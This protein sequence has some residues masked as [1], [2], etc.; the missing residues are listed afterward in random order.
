MATAVYSCLMP[1]NRPP[2]MNNLLIHNA[3]IYTENQVIPQGWLLCRAG[4]IAAVGAG[5]APA[6]DVPLLDARGQ[7]LLPGF[8]DV[9]VHGALGADT[10]D[11]QVEALRTM[12][13]FYAQQ[14]VTG[15]LPTTLTAPHADILAALEAVRQFLAE[16]SP[17][18]AVLGV[19]LEGP[20]LNVDK[21]G[22]QNP[23]YVRP[24]DPQE[25]QHYLDSGL[26]RVV[27]L[28][29]EVADNRELIAACA[30]RGIT[31]SIAHT[32]ATY[33]EARDA[34]AAGIRHATHTYNAMSGLHHRKPGTLGAVLEAPY[35]RCELIADNV[36]VHPAAM[37]LLWQAK[38][39][40][41][42]LLITDAMA[43]AGMPE[44][45]Y[46]LGALAVQV[47]DGRATL[48]DGTLAGSVLTMAQALRNF[49]AATN[50]TLEQAWPVSSLNAA[51]AIHRAHK[52][53]SIALG[54][55]ADLVLLDEALD[56]QATLV[57]GRVVFQQE[58]E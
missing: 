38:G 30:E 41:G 17:G 25:A 35:V 37:N 1:R 49:L 18:A 24:Y 27:S 39:R 55:Q 51:R 40:E 32:N 9:H 28:A 21:T 43:A 33:E 44:G 47:A 46:A 57:A 11:A 56:V 54:K 52:T 36:H 7:H 50:A 10:M 4:T 15:F 42:L 53:G 45:R 48:A 2:T 58:A 22:A 12:A 31:P 34:I 14:G 26:L 19:H 8:V 29:P 5:N 13:T 6:L 3:R 16:P 20:Y 23:Q